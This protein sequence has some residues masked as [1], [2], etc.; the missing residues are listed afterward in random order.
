MFNN[1]S[2]LGFLHLKLNEVKILDLN[3]SV[4]VCWVH[5]KHLK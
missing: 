3:E 5:S 4:S 1:V 2:N